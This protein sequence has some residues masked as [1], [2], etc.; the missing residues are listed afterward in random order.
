MKKQFLLCFSLV[1]S[2]L[3]QGAEKPKRETELAEFVEYGA[4]TYE[5]AKFSDFQKLHYL[6][7]LRRPDSEEKTRQL[8]L[9]F[10][11]FQDDNFEEPLMQEP[12]VAQQPDVSPVARQTAKEIA[13]D[14]IFACKIA[15]GIDAQRALR[16]TTEEMERHAQEAA[17]ADVQEPSALSSCGCTGACGCADNS[18]DFDR[19]VERRLEEE[20]DRCAI[21]LGD[22]FDC[23]IEC[24]RH[25]FHETCFDQWT[26]NSCPACG[27]TPNLDI[28]FFDE[29]MRENREKEKK[30][31]IQ[32]ELK[33]KKEKERLEQLALAAYKPSLDCFKSKHTDSDI[34]FVCKALLNASSTRVVRNSNGLLSH[35]SCKPAELPTYSG[36][37]SLDDSNTMDAFLNQWSLSKKDKK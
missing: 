3:V 27:I 33:D 10:E 16:E 35:I 11:A 34:C 32:K 31:R 6:R 14:E 7:L 36:Y 21:C 19:E 28:S 37:G 26:Q 18:T 2:G 30:A 9:F 20:K 12:V 4:R 13:F 5:T 15:A 25:F 29:F 24:C 22:D 1:C 23:T 8:Q 17:I